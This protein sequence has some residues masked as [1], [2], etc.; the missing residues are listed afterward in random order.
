MTPHVEIM[1]AASD[2]T[3]VSVVPVGEE[4]AVSLMSMNVDHKRLLSATMSVE[5]LLVVFIVNVSKGFNFRRTP[6]RVHVSCSTSNVINLRVVF[7]K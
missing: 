1:V 5:T 4:E 2:L 6:Q 7:V 3:C